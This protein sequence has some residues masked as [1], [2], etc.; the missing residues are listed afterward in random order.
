[1]FARTLLIE[2]AMAVGSTVAL[3]SLAASCPVDGPL[4]CHNNTVVADT[5]C[6]NAPGGQLLLTQFWDTKPVTGPED[7]WTIHGLWYGCPDFSFLAPPPRALLAY[8]WTF[9]LQA[10][11]TRVQAGQL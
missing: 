4:S 2:A 10:L 1:M 8:L 3:G 7:S 5:C 6:F 11:T 9:Y